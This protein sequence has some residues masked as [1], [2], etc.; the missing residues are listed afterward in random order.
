MNEILYNYYTVQV[1][2]LYIKPYSYTVPSILEIKHS[3]I[4]NYVFLKLYENQL[5][6]HESTEN[7]KELIYAQCSIMKE[8]YHTNNTPCSCTATAAQMSELT[9]THAR[10]DPACMHGLMPCS[11]H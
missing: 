9:Q 6:C 11:P 2:I 8:R 4:D 5:Q 7:I 3:I 1:I 10:S